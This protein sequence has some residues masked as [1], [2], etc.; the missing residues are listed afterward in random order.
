MK[1]NNCGGDSVEVV[2]TVREKDPRIG[3]YEIQNAKYF[4]CT[5][6]NVRLYPVET[7]RRLDA[8]RKRV[9]VSMIRR[10][11][12]GEFISAAETAEYLGVTRQALHK[13]KRVRKGFIYQTEV[14]G[15]TV[16][17]RM[18]VEL[19]KK[20][21]DGRFPLDETAV[22]LSPV[23]PFVFPQPRTTKS[24]VVAEGKVKYVIKKK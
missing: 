13:H 3:E 23:R 18:S 6:C 1:C 17:H 14:S 22:V 12:I 8:E 5:S 9:L 11:P 15:K 20:T 7:A 21:G 16:Y 4:E 10:R 2:G 19:F 24:S